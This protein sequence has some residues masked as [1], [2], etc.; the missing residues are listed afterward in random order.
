ML[1][2]TVLLL[3][4]LFAGFYGK[5]IDAL[6]AYKI[7]YT[8]TDE[9]VEPYLEI[10]W[11]INPAT[12]PFSKSAKGYWQSTVKTEVTLTQS[13]KTI[14]NDAYNLQSAPAISRQVALLQNI[15]DLQ[16][17]KVGTGKLYIKILLTDDN[18]KNYL[19]SDSVLINNPDKKVFYSDVQLVDTSYKSDVTNNIYL[20]NGYLQIPL[21]ADFADNHRKLLH[22]YFE[23]YGTDK[24]TD[25]ERPVIQT[26]YIS[27]KENDIAVYKL[28]TTDTLDLNN[29]ISPV[30]GA[31]PIDVLPSGNY[32]LNTEITDKNGH[33]LDKKALFFQRSNL[34]PV[35]IKEGEEDN[36]TSLFEKVTVFDL[37]E[38]FVEE[39]TPPQ[40]KA[41]LKMLLPISSSSEK[42][43]IE[44][45]L[46][47]PEELYMRYFIYNFWKNRAPAEPGRAWKDYTKKVKE[48]NK[49]FGSGRTPGYE[50]ERGFVYLKY[51]KPDQRYTVS[52]EEGA[53]PYEV[54]QYNAAGIQQKY[55]AFL[56]YNPGFMMND[57]R[58]L[59]STVIG[60]TLNPNWR[61][62]LYKSGA[63]S[64]N[65]NSRA[66]QV[67]QIR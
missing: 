16:R 27:K 24:L 46:K 2:K 23:L 6:T 56:F 48:V 59:H 32:Y 19:F 45:F 29:A 51:G 63:P 13:G 53:W 39:Y 47:R 20:R 7:F 43:N 40:L 52:N 62:Q 60:E 37:S 61:S 35:S 34:K 33:L 42:T 26:I 18:N 55:G 44:G 41:I 5:A 8:Y 65:L 22:Y 25:E 3:Y 12:I 10:Y 31:F 50:T 36:D 67:F 58:L 15:S 14:A 28:R 21:S 49:L 57:Y 17:Y 66:E 38:T 1:R 30:R 54:W 11:Q 4:L 9:G 64:G